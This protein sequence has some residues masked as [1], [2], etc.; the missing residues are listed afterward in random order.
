MVDYGTTDGSAMAGS[1]YG[2]VSGTLTF[3]PGVT[4]RSIAVPIL[5][6][7]LDE[8]DETMTLKLPHPVAA[9]ITG[10]NPA[11]LTIVDDQGPGV[12]VFAG[13]GE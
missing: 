9:V 10:T 13:G 1:D 5:D 2:R 8:A 11:T 4:A 3:D 12:V 7:A 6:D